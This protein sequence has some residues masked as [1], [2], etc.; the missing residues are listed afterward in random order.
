MAPP[1]SE[2]KPAEP[3][4]YHTATPVE[5]A[6]GA[7]VSL[8]DA[9]VTLRKRKFVIIVLGVLGICYGLYKNA[10]QP[11]LYSSYGRIEIRSGSSNQ[12]RVSGA[13]DVSGGSGNSR[14]PTEVVILKSDT[15]LFTVAQDL[16]LANNPDF[17]GLKQRPPRANTDDPGIR[18]GL[19]GKLSDMLIVAQVPKTD[20]VMIVCK[21]PSGKLSADIVNKLIDEYI[22][23]SVESRVDSQKRASNFLTGTLDDLKHKVET[24]QEQLID[25]QKNLGMLAI[26]PTHNEISASLDELTKAAGEAEI[27]RILAESRY[28]VLSGMDPE[29]LDENVANLTGAVP[30]GGYV[31]TISG[32]SGSGNSV[33]NAPATGPA[34]TELGGLRQQLTSMQADVAKLTAPGNLDT[35]HPRVQADLSGI[36]EIKKQ[37][38][39]AQKRVVAQ[40]KE[41]YIAAQADE[42]QTRAALEAEKSEAYKLRDDLVEYT[43]RQREFES[44]RT[45]Y[46][47]LVSRL[48]TASVQAGLEGTEI[49]IV[50]QAMPPP[51]PT[52]ETRSSLVI[53]NTLIALLLGVVLAFVLESL[54]SGLRSVAEIETISGLPSLALIPRSRRTGVPASTLSI[55]QRNVGALSSPKSQFTEAFRALRTSLLLSTAGSLPK[56]ILLTS[57]T[58]SEGKTTICTNLACV[59]AQN[60]VR[61]LMIDGDLRRPTV[62]HRLGLNGK[63]GLTSILTGTATLEQAVQKLPELPNLEILVSGPV[64]PFPTEMLG[65]QTMIDLLEQ[66]RG[67]YTHVVIDSPPLLSVTDGVVLA[68]SAD[69]V[70]LIVRHGRSGKQTVRRARDLLAR[71]GA[72]VTGIAI[73]AVDLSSPEYYGYYG[74][75]VYSG[76][77]SSSVETAAWESKSGNGNGE[78]GDQR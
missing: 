42:A 10:T 73:N 48:Q 12:Y 29:T 16:D 23:R 41:T 43:I 11:R 8:S 59:L 22:T 34:S 37:I 4:G 28:R 49:D 61:V 64:P 44:D 74:Y 39:A 5:S 70:V 14:I 26:D 30:A 75:S 27:T 31:S 71:A 78:K 9:L 77:G 36:E 18:Q 57:A 52:V 51:G 50:D 62:H 21:S 19:I 24:A 56:V 7:D 68:R 58:P 47:G 60:D 1:M 15:L 33:A 32:V 76:Y 25:L 46:E 6:A 17:L 72:P 66:C 13:L 40:A 65:S 55:A 38:A 45:L 53:T 63:I 20:L 54:D 69:A 67:I 2:N 3:G 35:N